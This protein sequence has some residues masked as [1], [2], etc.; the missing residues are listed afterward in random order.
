MPIRSRSRNGI[1]GGI[2]PMA[3]A[4]GARPRARCGHH[5]SDQGCKRQPVQRQRDP[6]YRYFPGRARPG[7]GAAHLGRPW[8][9]E[10]LIIPG[11]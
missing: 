1:E 6:Y 11:R 10:L 5:P 2:L 8:S 4:T 9:K 7:A 3:A